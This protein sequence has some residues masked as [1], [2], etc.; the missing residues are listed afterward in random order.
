MHDLKGN[1]LLQT[2]AVYF[3]EINK[4]RKQGYYIIGVEYNQT[5]KI[6]GAFRD[7]QDYAQSRDIVEQAN[8]LYS[9]PKYF[10]YNPIN[11]SKQGGA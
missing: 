5:Y 3:E 6:K 11:N 9:K 8:K 7:Y 10:Y 2:K 1:E 4:L